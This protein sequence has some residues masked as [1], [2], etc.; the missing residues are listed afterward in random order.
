MSLVACTDKKRKHRIS[1]S[2]WLP[3]IIVHIIAILIWIVCFVSDSI[4]WLPVVFTVLYYFLYCFSVK[5]TKALVKLS[6]WVVFPS[7]LLTV[8]G[9]LALYIYCFYMYANPNSIIGDQQVIIALVAIGIY[10]LLPISII[11]RIIVFVKTL[12]KS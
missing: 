4:V 1:A 5:K 6:N 11:L 12:K 2:F 9:D 8:L 10:V 7:I 3:S